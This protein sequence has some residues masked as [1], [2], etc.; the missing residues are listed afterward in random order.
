MAFPRSPAWMPWILPLVAAGLAAIVHAPVL[1]RFFLHDDYLHLYRSALDGVPEFWL[2]PHGGHALVVWRAVFEAQRALF[3]LEAAA[4]FASVLATHC[5]NVALLYGATRALT[6]RPGIALFVASVWGVAPLA[7]GSLSW[8]SVFGNVLMTTWT[9]W[10]VYEVVRVARGESRVGVFAVL[11]WALLMLL[12]ANSFG[13]GLGVAIAFPVAVWLLLASREERPH[14]VA[15]LFALPPAAVA[16]YLSVLAAAPELIWR[17]PEVADAGGYGL[18]RIHF[19]AGLVPLQAEL[20]GRLVAYAMASVAAGPLLVV[21]LWLSAPA[22]D[23]VAGAAAGVATPLLP[24]AALLGLALAVALATRADT[25]ARREGL[26]FALLAASAYAPV[27]FAR[28]IAVDRF[29]A[30]IWLVP[31]YHYLGTALVWLALCALLPKL[32]LGRS[33]RRAIVLL[34][35]A[36]LA[37]AVW[38]GHRSGADF[39]VPGAEESRAAFSRSKQRIETAVAGRAE[40]GTAVIVNRPFDAFGH[41]EFP[42]EAGIFVILAPR[43]ERAGVAV[44]FEERHAPT[45][46]AHRQVGGPRMRELLV[47]PGGVSP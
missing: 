41:A 19:Q 23:P 32:E 9:L 15:W 30:Q 21:P 33:A 13:M 37:L 17:P 22:I 25:R 45:R 8:L 39:D 42:G 11:R 7:R 10:A 29:D 16:L 26:A 2:R 36:W 27:A 4:W 24:V 38:T 47:E 18:L 46:A 6:R 44:R 28:A 40:G 5:V 1:E 31:R 34:A 3:G 14:A 43:N 35:S 12:A 20:F